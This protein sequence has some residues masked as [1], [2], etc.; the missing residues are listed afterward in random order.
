M[1]FFLFH[2]HLK[3]GCLKKHFDLL[4]ENKCLPKHTFQLKNIDIY[5]LNI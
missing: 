5:L 2:V 3:I 4:S 1:Y